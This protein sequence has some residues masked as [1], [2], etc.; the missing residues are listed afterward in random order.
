MPLTLD[1]LGRFKRP[2]SRARSDAPS[3]TMTMPWQVHVRQPSDT[4]DE[5]V[6]DPASLNS[7]LKLGSMGQ[8]CETKGAP[9]G[10]A[11]SDVRGEAAP[12]RVTGNPPCAQETDSKQIADEQQTETGTPAMMLGEVSQHSGRLAAKELEKAR[13]L[14]EAANNRTVNRQQTDS[15][16][17]ANRQQ[18]DSS[19]QIGNRQQ[20]DSM[21]G[22]GLSDRPI[23]KSSE[24]MPFRGSNEWRGGVEWVS[25]TDSKR[26]ANSYQR[27][28]KQIA[29][30]QQTDST[31]QI[32]DRQKTNSK[33]GPDRQLAEPRITGRA[34]ELATN[35]RLNS[36]FAGLSVSGVDRQTDSKQIADKKLPNSNANAHLVKPS[37]GTAPAAPLVKSP[38]SAGQQTVSK[39][40]ANRQQTDRGTDPKPP[41][42]LEA[43][44][45]AERNEATAP[46]AG[47]HTPATQGSSPDVDTADSLP[48]PQP[49]PSEIFRRSPGRPPQERHVE[50][51]SKQIATH[52]PP[53]ADGHSDD[54]APVGKG[55]L[56]G[57]AAQLAGHMILPGARDSGIPGI[58]VDG[59][60]SN[61]TR[62]VS[63]GASI[64]SL[65]DAPFPTGSETLQ[66]NRDNPVAPNDIRASSPSLSTPPVYLEAPLYGSG[67]RHPADK[68]A[69]KG[70]QTDSKSPAK[71][72][73][74]DS[75]QL[76]DGQQTGSVS[77]KELANSEQTGSKQLAEQ[78]ANGQQTGSSI[79]SLTTLSG[80]QR[81]LVVYLADLCKLAC[82]SHTPPVRI[83]DLAVSIGTTEGTAK[84][85]VLRVIEKGFLS[86]HAS[87]TGRGGWSQYTMPHHIYREALEAATA[88]APSGVTATGSKRVAEQVA[89]TPSSSRFID[90]TTTTTLAERTNDKQLAENYAQALLALDFD[91]LGASDAMQLWRTGKFET[92]SDV[93]ESI[94]HMAFY[95]KAGMAKD[96]GKPKAFAMRELLKGYFGR[97]AGFM[98]AEERAEAAKV[99][100]AEEKAQRLR[101]LRLRRAEAEFDC[102]YEELPA[103]ERADLLKAA[104]QGGPFVNA[105]IAKASLR[106]EYGLRFAI[107]EFLPAEE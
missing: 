3:K 76:A 2:T 10:E 11:L 58:H 56:E 64:S 21:W 75:K 68:E 31:Q 99:E 22:A 37:A 30:G 45:L 94:E 15:E 89:K 43:Q 97:P 101:E 19:K 73:Q 35:K 100:A 85:V 13:A 25:E 53:L 46:A 28:S 74:T 93:L 14:A 107:P 71:G 80:L 41:C 78:L 52:E 66:A 47:A 63:L 26:I 12:D 39:Q 92:P 79:L 33:K 95:I 49:R 67:S 34:R 104:G 61:L 102:W 90:L 7:P 17:T 38:R 65:P 87:K 91:L 62:H 16:Q 86:I 103:N 48:A 40:I 98:S 72:Q 9:G 27:D 96:V 69:A 4:A 51:V 32:A 6:V 59:P 77:L 54:Q 84:N 106:K 18:T 81:A 8:T 1:D 105:R 36:Q 88:Y 82:S 83:S 20:T 23:D 42:P 55:R 50:A 44:P 24:S 57:P 5:A 29:D 60:R 70:Q